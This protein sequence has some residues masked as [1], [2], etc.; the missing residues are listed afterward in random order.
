MYNINDNWPI[1]MKRM[2]SN[3]TSIILAMRLRNII[4]RCAF[5]DCTCIYLFC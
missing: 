2:L 5:F 4:A 1:G 3:D